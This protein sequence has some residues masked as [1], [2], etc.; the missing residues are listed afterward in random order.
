MTTGLFEV[1]V[2]RIWLMR[3]CRCLTEDAIIE[4]A[5]VFPKRNGLVV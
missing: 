3:E 1:L 4:P 5:S 2:C